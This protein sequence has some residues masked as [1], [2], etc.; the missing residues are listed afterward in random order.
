[1]RPAIL[2][3]GLT[4]LLTILASVSSA[5]PQRVS[6]VDES[7]KASSQSLTPALLTLSGTIFTAI[8]AVIGKYFYDLNLARRKDRLD[9]INNQLR[10]LY[11]PLYAS[12]LAAREVWQAFWRK[13]DRDPKNPNLRLRKLTEAEMSEWRTWVTEV[14]MPLNERMERAIVENADLFVGNE[15]PQ[16]LLLLC[17]HVASYKALRARWK[18]GDISEASPPIDY[19]AKEFRAHIQST[20]LALKNEQA[21]LLAHVRGA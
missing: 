12:D 10:L 21:S 14:F 7:P 11:G 4:L 6:P 9:R 1:M 19:P 5:S 8:L 16:G 15:I 13:M 3:S 17:A 18:A 20:F 2:A